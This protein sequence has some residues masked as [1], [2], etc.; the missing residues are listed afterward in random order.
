M[1]KLISILISMLIVMTFL[2]VIAS[3]ESNSNNTYTFETEDTNY[4][5]TFD[6]NNLSEEQQKIVAEKLVFDNDDSTQTYGLGCT[7]F[8]HDYL[9]DTAYVIT[10]KVR[11]SQPRCKEDTY[12]VKYCEDCDFM[13]ETLI[14]SKYIYCCD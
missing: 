3:A 9:Y 8:G 4:T 7:L 2:C 11:S 14:N 6:G 13:E 5:V 12:D 10:H 1:K